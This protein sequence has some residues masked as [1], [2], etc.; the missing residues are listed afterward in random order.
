MLC[1]LEQDGE[2]ASYRL[3]LG[4]GGHVRM[5]DVKSPLPTFKSLKALVVHF[6]T[7]SGGQL[8]GGVSLTRCIPFTE[9]ADI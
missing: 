9:S 6:M 8:L 7:P 4:S 3:K 5:L 2:V 1:V